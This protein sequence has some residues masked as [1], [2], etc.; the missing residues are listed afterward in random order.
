MI[1]P[2][3]YACLAVLVVYLLALGARVIVEGLSR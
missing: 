1:E 3:G 2:L